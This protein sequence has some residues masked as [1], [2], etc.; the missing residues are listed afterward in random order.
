LLVGDELRAAWTTV[1]LG[2]LS[3]RAAVIVAIAFEKTWWCD[4]YAQPV[5]SNRGSVKTEERLLCVAVM[6]NVHVLAVDNVADSP[7]VVRYSQRFDIVFKEERPG[8]C[9][10]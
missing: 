2:F 6:K 3:V 5:C 4:L 10:H 9:R 1:W 7:S 8:G